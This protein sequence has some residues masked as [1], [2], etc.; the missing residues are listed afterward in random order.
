MRELEAERIWEWYDGIVLGTGRLSGSDETRLVSQLA[1]DPTARRRAY[2]LLP[3]EAPDL[4]A[5]EAVSQDWH[6]DDMRVA[7]L[8]IYGSR[9]ADASVVV[10]DSNWHVVHG[11]TM[12]LADLLPDLFW[13][14]EVT[15]EL[16]RRH[17][18]T[19][20]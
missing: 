3:V 7:L 15:T 13:D 2:A 9:H 16:S 11:R 1:F 12:K 6:D 10:V 20:E 18:L 8:A 5:L 4:A 17:W 14:V 19:P